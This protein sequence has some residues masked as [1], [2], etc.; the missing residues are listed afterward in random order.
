[1][2]MVFSTLTFSIVG[3]NWS[4]MILLSIARA[5]LRLPL[6]TGQMWIFSIPISYCVLLTLKKL[7][8]RDWGEA[9]WVHYCTFFAILALSGILYFGFKLSAVGLA[10]SWFF[11]SWLP[12][13]P[14]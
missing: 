4:G 10:Y 1:M 8:T 5:T 7:Y 3:L 11:A 13:F 9:I 14:I 6:D 2:V 12:I